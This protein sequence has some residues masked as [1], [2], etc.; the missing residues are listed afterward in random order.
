M[1]LHALRLFYTVAEEGNVT[2][3]AKT[4]YKS[5]CCDSSD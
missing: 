3:A 4:K 2:C 1:N 5:A